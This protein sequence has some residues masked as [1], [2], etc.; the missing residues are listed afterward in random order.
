MRKYYT[1]ANEQHSKWGPASKPYNT[2]VFSRSMFAKF[3]IDNYSCGSENKNVKS[4]LEF[5]NGIDEGYDE[6][7][8]KVHVEFMNLQLVRLIHG[9]MV[10]IAAGQSEFIRKMT[11]TVLNLAK[12]KC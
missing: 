4:P 8:R 10:I 11:G 9:T 2:L 1:V 5:R 6:E 3:R 7:R 12:N